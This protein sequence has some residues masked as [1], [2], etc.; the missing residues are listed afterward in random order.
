MHRVHV[1]TKVNAEASEARREAAHS[2]A[3]MTF[4]TSQYQQAQEA[5]QLR[6]RELETAAG[7]SAALQAQLLA[8]QKEAEDKSTALDAAKTEGRA[9][10]LQVSLLAYI[11][12]HWCC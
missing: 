11:A 4:M 12:M 9:L 7:R 3:Q 6:A 8:A 10:A 2:N 5:L 1:Q